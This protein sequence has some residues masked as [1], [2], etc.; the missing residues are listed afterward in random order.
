MGDQVLASCRTGPPTA[1][2]SALHFKSP[3]RAWMPAARYARTFEI[4]SIPVPRTF[5]TAWLG[6]RGAPRKPR[7][8]SRTCRTFAARGVD[9]SLPETTLK[10]L[11]LEHLVRNYTACCCQWMTTWGVLEW[12]DTTSSRRR[13]SWSTLGQ[14][15]FLGEHGLF[16]KR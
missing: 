4:R 3:H 10:R 7:W 9:H 6:G 12:L 16:D 8:R 11:N 1:I 5:E 2:L 14:R 15:L 13:R